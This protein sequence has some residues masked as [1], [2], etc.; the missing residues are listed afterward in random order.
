M[1][2]EAAAV[3]AK[4]LACATSRP[5]PAIRD[6]AVASAKIAVLRAIRRRGGEGG[7]GKVDSPG[8]VLS[9]DTSAL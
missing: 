6:K 2:A 1:K 7:G 3:V 4:K 5:S 9:I 8:S